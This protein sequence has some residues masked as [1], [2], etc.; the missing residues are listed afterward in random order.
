[1]TRDKPSA[2]LQ[3]HGNSFQEQSSPSGIGDFHFGEDKKTYSCVCCQLVLHY[4]PQ[5][6]ESIGCSVKYHD[7]DQCSIIRLTPNITVKLV[8][9]TVSHL[10]WGTHDMNNLPMPSWWLTI[11]FLAPYA[12]GAL[13]LTWINYNPSMVKYMRWKVWD[14]ITYL[15]L[16]LLHRWSLRLD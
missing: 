6:T 13:L 2:K 12:P 8:T 9:H 4:P 7:I 15:K 10:H 1:M 11:Y 16:H 3:T 14:G 5:I